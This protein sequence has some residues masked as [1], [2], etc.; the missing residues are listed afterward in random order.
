MIPLLLSQGSLRALKGSALGSALHVAAANGLG[1]QALRMLV[2]EAGE[3][4]QVNHRDETP[5]YRACC[6]Y[7]E[8]DETVRVLLELGADWTITADNGKSPLEE[9]Q[10]R[11]YHLS[12]TH[13]T[14][15]IAAKNKKYLK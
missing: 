12:C 5:L 11:L 14:D 1:E 10:A 4:N 15:A 6:A 2:L 13:I 7:P 9:A 8:A 3:I